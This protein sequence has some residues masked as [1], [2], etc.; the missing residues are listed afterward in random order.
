MRKTMFGLAVAAAA[1]L[2]GCGDNEGRGGLTA[3]EERQ[4]DNAAA[5]LDDNMIDVS[6]DSLEANEAE[7]E[8]M[9]AEQGGGGNSIEGNG[10]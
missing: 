6:P 5:M 2:A 4:L 9:D 8:A 10:L 3:D 7:L 1:L